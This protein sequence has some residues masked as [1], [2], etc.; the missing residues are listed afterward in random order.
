MGEKLFLKMKPSC[1]W[2]SHKSRGTKIPENIKVSDGFLTWI[3]SLSCLEIF[4]NIYMGIVFFRFYV[5]SK[6]QNG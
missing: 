3:S 5:K 2:K 1:C 6:T 4:I